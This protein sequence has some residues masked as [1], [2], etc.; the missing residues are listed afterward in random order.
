M[1]ALLKKTLK[2]GS[3][4]RKYARDRT[5]HDGGKRKINKSSLL[6]MMFI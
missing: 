5:S 3:T 2:K 1:R 6:D 4:I